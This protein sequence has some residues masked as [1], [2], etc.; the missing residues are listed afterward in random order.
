MKKVIDKVISNPKFHEVYVRGCNYRT[1][2]CCGNELLTVV[3]SKEGEDRYH[4]IHTEAGYAFTVT[5]PGLF[6][7]EPHVLQEVAT[8]NPDTIDG[9][10]R[11]TS[12]EILSE[13]L[14]EDCQRHICEDTFI[15]FD[16]NKFNYVIDSDGLK[17]FAGDKDRKRDQLRGL[18]VEDY[19]VVFK[20][21][22]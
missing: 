14:I 8:R 12:W 3:R 10:L 4:Y 13:K 19:D 6:N 20:M 21:I 9:T 15:F 17:M 7:A 18:Q 2:A 5:A 22:Y 16:H 11:A 1:L